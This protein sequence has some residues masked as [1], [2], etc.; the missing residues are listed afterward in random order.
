MVIHLDVIGPKIQIQI[1]VVC[2][3]QSHVTYINTCTKFNDIN[4]PGIV[5]NFIIAISDI[6]EICIAP[7]TAI[8]C[9]VSSKADERIVVPQT[10]NIFT[11]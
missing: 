11:V 5:I 8:K 7:R 10:I 1:T 4:H 2:V 9:I 3:P 6:V